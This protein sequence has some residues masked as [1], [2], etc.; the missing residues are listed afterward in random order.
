MKMWEFTKFAVCTHTLHKL[1]PWRHRHPHV[2]SWGAILKNPY[3]PYTAVSCSCHWLACALLRSFHGGRNQSYLR[4]KK[5][6]YKR[7]WLPY[8]SEDSFTEFVGGGVGETAAVKIKVGKVE[9]NTWACSMWRTFWIHKHLHD[10]KLRLTPEKEEIPTHRWAVAPLCPECFET[11]FPV[12]TAES[13]Y[14]CSLV[15]LKYW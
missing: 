15:K 7:T 2:C 5:E 6:M 11:N 9:R 4:L 1:L 13:G 12:L 8:Y 14:F 10:Q 3:H